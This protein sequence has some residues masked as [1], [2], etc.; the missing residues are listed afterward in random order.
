MNLC[1]QHLIESILNPP[2]DLDKETEEAQDWRVLFAWY[3][4]LYKADFCRLS[5]WATFDW[6]P[7]DPQL[8]PD[9]VSDEVQVGFD[10]FADIWCEPLQATFN[11]EPFDPQL[12][13]DTVTEEVQDVFD[14]FQLDRLLYKSDFFWESSIST[15]DSEPFGP[16]LDFDAETEEDRDLFNL[17]P[18]KNSLNKADICYEFWWLTQDYDY[19][20]PHKD[21]IWEKS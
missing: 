10:L 14:L 9:A 8:N 6:E 15:F 11:W 13:I 20:S 18:E 1:V 2:L 16:Q 7:F 17:F 21:L 4:S 19:F 12:D 3:L 5:L